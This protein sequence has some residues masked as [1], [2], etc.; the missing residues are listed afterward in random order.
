MYFSLSKS[1]CKQEEN[2]EKRLSSNQ[3]SEE[4]RKKREAISRSKE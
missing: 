4:M 1:E 3:I 2:V